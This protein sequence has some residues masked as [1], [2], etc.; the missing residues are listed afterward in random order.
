MDVGAGYRFVSGVESYDLTDS[1]I[2]G[3]SLNVTFKFGRF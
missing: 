2:G 3:P 1:D